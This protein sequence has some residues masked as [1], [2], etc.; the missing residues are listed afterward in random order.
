MGWVVCATMRA[1]AHKSTSTKSSVSS[2]RGSR[3]ATFLVGVSTS[4]SSLT[5][6]VRKQ[7]RARDFFYYAEDHYH[8]DQIRMPFVH[9][10]FERIADGH[11]LYS[12]VQHLTKIGASAPGGGRWHYATL[13][14]IIR[15]EAYLGTFWWGKKVTTTPVSLVENGERYYRKKVQK[16]ERPRSEWIVVPVPDSG[17]PPETIAR[18]RETLKGNTRAVSK[19]SGRI[20]ELS[21]GVGVCSE[22]GSRIGAYTTSNATQKRYHYYRC[23]NREGNVCPNRK[24]YRAKELELLVR[25]TIVSTFQPETWADFVNDVCDRQAE[26]LRKLHR[27]DLHKTK[28]SLVK[29]IGALETKIARAR[30]LFIEGDLPRPE[31]GEKK[32]ST[33]EQIEVVR[34]ELSKIDNLDAEM[35]RI[36]HLRDALLSVA[37][38]Y[39]GHYAFTGG[40]LDLDVFIDKNLS[41]GS[42]E[43]AAKRRQEFYRQVGLRVKVG[44][45]TEISLDIGR[46]P[47]S[48]CVSFSCKTPTSR[49]SRP[50]S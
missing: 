48:K 8:I 26:D 10:I 17:I 20:W 45:E 28:E 14:N 23:S 2:T 37:S 12:T 7:V 41:Y 39:S 34:L 42:R 44:Q 40:G 16:E 35:Q 5:T 43:T 31:Y 19:N 21:G 13:R 25:D 24:N 32:T 22:C 27:S 30:E 1:S 9:E 50:A 47:V 49:S 38:P 6:R 46:S 4:S 15:N 36:D 3:P 33:Q 11:S 29:W 18:A